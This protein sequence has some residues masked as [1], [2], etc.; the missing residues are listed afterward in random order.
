MSR[1]R[2][3]AIVLLAALLA[4]LLC[5]SPATA[6]EKQRQ[7]QTAEKKSAGAGKKAKPAEEKAEKPL[8][9]G[10]AWILIDSRTGEVILAHNAAKQLPIASTTKLMT[11]YVAI[12][13]MPLDKL[14]KAQPYDPI[15]GE[16]LMGL[17]VGQEISVRDLLY[18]LILRSGNDAAHTLAIAA[19]GSTDRFVAQMNR[20]AAALGLADTHYAN[21]VGLDQKG[22]YS[23]ARDLATLTQR[24]LRIPAF[25]KVADSR[26]AV[27]RSVHPRRRI[28][29]INELLLDAPWVTGV[30]TGHTFDAA[31]VLVGS[32]RK[33]GVE[34]ISDA[35]GAPSDEARYSDNLELLEYGFRQY[36]RRLPIHAGQDLADPAIRYSGGE[37]PLRAARSVAVGLR[38]GQ[39]LSLEVRAPREVEGPIERGAALGQA[40]VF[41]DGLRAGAVPL[42]AGRAIPEAGAFDRARGFLGNNSIPI[43][44]AVFVILM[45]G[46]LLYRRKS[47][48]TT[49]G[50]RNRVN[51]K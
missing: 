8:V 5:L 51:V 47:R 23:S 13:D 30:K 10:R 26:E 39:R 28:T 25:A 32:G 36:K 48:A 12:K 33:K 42:R 2:A 22:N 4:W 16:S 40:T 41:V 14:V 11:A 37:L 44:V 43:A 21:P 49:K 19:A 50:K 15:Y 27:L 7:E 45:A 35:I 17:R 6:A 1:P 31:Y 38:R 34:L 29:T 18:G 3:G 46:V 24:L 20:Y 9:E